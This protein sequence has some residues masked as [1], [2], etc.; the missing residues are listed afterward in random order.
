MR[1]ARHATVAAL[2]AALAAVLL[3][4]PLAHAQTSVLP[5]STALPSSTTAPAG[6]PGA[7]APT[8]AQPP[9]TAAVQTTATP[10]TASTGTPASTGTGTRSNTDKKLPVLLLAILGAILLAGALAIAAARWWAYDPPWLVRA[11]HS[12]AEAGWRTS[13][14]WAEFRDW[15]RLGR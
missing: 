1:R 12:T 10:Q 14:A 6:T 11:R 13:A 2:T 15:L 9:T 3:V 4:V 7:P 8:T 5:G